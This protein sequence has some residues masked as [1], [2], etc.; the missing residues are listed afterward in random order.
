VGVVRRGGRGVVRAPL[1][2]ET[3]PKRKRQ[4]FNES[5]ESDRGC[6]ITIKFFLKK[7][8]EFEVG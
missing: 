1:N 8:Y 6:R 2:D 4:C 7:S 5:I 3:M